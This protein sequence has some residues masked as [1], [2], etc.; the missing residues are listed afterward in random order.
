MI[1]KGEIGTQPE[2]MGAEGSLDQIDIVEFITGAEVEVL[3]GPK[4]SSKRGH[5]ADRR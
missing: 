3:V 5:P 4:L 2:Q 1:G